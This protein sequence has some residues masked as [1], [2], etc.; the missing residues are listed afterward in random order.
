MASRKSRRKN[1]VFGFVASVVALAVVATLTARRGRIGP[2]ALLAV[3]RGKPSTH[4]GSSGAPTRT[5][6][7]SSRTTTRASSASSTRRSSATTRSRTS[8]FPGSRAAGSG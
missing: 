7:R 8:S 1:E 3:P 6:T 2:Q 5:S 4:R